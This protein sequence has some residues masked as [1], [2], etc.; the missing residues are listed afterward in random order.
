MTANICDN[1]GMNGNRC[2]SVRQ[3]ISSIPSVIVHGSSTENQSSIMEPGCDLA[4]L[5]IN[6]SASPKEHCTASSVAFY[7]IRPGKECKMKSD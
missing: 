7:P 6:Q 1:H 3:D 2:C 5:G 4:A